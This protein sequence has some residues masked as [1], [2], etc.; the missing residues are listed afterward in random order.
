MGKWLPGQPQVKK[1]VSQSHLKVHCLPVL[2]ALLV[3]SGPEA[4]PSLIQPHHEGA[5]GWRG[6]PSRAE[7]RPPVLRK[8]QALTLG[9]HK[10]QIVPNSKEFFSWLQLPYMPGQNR[11]TWRILCLP[12]GW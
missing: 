12:Q 5:R 1:A 6:T 8:C 9:R 11:H 10:S 4:I 7:L 2:P 3:V